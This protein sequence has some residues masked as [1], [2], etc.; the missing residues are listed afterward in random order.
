MSDRVK[1]EQPREGVIYLTVGDVRLRIM[2]TGSLCIQERGKD[3]RILLDSL[4]SDGSLE[5]AE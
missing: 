3:G 2:T 1:I 4:V 5:A